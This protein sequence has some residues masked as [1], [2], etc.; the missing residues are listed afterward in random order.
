MIEIT[1]DAPSRE[2]AEMWAAAGKHLHARMEGAPTWMKCELRLPILEHLSFRLGNQL[3]FVRVEGEGKR[4]L[5]PGNR[6]GLASI[7]RGCK[8]H[9]C[10]MPMK[11]T[12]S[13]WR[14]SLP[15]WGLAELET[16]MPLDPPALIT[17]ELVEMTDWELQD[18]AVQV[19]RDDLE[20]E[21]RQLMSWHSNPAVSPSIW[22]VGDNGPEWVVVRAVRYPSREAEPPT[23][24]AEIAGECSRLGRIGHFASVAVA[25]ADGPQEP[26]FLARGHA[27]EVAYDGLR[28]GPE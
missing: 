26:S 25:A 22:F 15:G 5:C 13:G 6:G 9:A 21:G 10:L 2:F 4:V 17:D 3:F 27:L 11:W 12:A 7:A 16:G 1:M 23:N 14:P 8:G 28:P 19:V 18:F 20:G 24:W